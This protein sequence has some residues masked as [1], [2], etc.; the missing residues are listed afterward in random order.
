WSKEVIQVVII[1]STIPSF[2]GRTTSFL[3]ATNVHRSLRVG[4]SLIFPCVLLLSVVH[5]DLI[6]KST[7]IRRLSERRTRKIG[8]ENPGEAHFVMMCCCCL[9]I[10]MKNEMVDFSKSQ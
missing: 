1:L 2:H 9:S 7:T 4:R 10:E 6:S 3:V 8:A 5:L